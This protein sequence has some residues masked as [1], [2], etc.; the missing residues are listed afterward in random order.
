MCAREHVLF[1]S[2][3]RKMELQYNDLL[4]S[5]ATVD[6]LWV[7]PYEGSSTTYHISRQGGELSV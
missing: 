1:A 4:L 6:R 2:V 7:G 5:V 3:L